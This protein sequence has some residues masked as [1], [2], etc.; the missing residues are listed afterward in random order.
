MRCEQVAYTAPPML[1][2]I[3]TNT[4][5]PEKEVT[6]TVAGP[7]PAEK[8]NGFV[9]AP[10]F[11]CGTCSAPVCSKCLESVQ[12]DGDEPSKK[13]SKTH[14]C[15]PDSVQTIRLLRKDSRA[16]PGCGVFIHKIQGCSQIWCTQCHIAFD[17]STGVIEKGVVHNPHYFDFIRQTRIADNLVGG[18]ECGGLPGDR[19]FTYHIYGLEDCLSRQVI[20]LMAEWYR[21]VAHIR[22]TQLAGLRRTVTREDPEHGRTVIQTGG[23]VNV[24]PYTNLRVRFLLNRIDE[25]E[26]SKQLQRAEKRFDVCN[27]KFRL[28]D[29]LVSSATDLIGTFHERHLLPDNLSRDQK[30]EKLLQTLH[31]LDRF[32][33]YADTHADRISK[34]YNIAFSIRYTFQLR[35]MLAAVSF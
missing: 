9:M 1:E 2:G 34:V 5:R 14:V 6:H 13:H 23:P 32:K 17:F 27:A 28:V 19:G 3:A 31:A 25:N 12:S 15:N 7:C 20:S 8:C 29:T 10:E 21:C 22:D 16:C 24:P 4:D 26:W 30:A 18:C 11:K 33:A 35:K